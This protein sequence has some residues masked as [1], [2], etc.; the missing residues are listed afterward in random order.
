MDDKQ[1]HEDCLEK[2]MNQLADSVL[3]QSDEAIFDEM[4][5]DGE[6]PVAAAE[7]ARTVLR[8]ASES[9]DNLNRRLSNLGHTINSKFWRNVHGKYYNNCLVCGSSVSLTISTGETRGRALIECCSACGKYA[10]AKRENIG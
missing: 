3:A 5:Q 6:D 2:I 4:S 9:V 1:T 8:C 10:N 7:R